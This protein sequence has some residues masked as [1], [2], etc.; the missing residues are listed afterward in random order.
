VT[1]G[2]AAV[3]ATR[4]KNLGGT[5][6]AGRGTTGGSK[7]EGISGASRRGRRGLDHERRCCAQQQPHPLEGSTFRRR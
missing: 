3:V 7:P 6:G 4:G 2:G 5:A 1:A